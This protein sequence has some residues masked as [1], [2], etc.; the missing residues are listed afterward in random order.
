MQNEG[1]EGPELPRI[2]QSPFFNLQFAV[3]Y[4]P[5]AQSLPLSSVCENWR[6]WACARSR[7]L[8]PPCRFR[9]SEATVAIEQLLK[10]VPAAALSHEAP[11][12]EEDNALGPWREAAARIVE[13]ADDDEVW[14]RL[15]WGPASSVPDQETALTPFRRV[16]RPF[17][18]PDGEEGRHVR[19][20]LQA[21]QPALELLELGIQRGRVQLPESQDTQGFCESLDWLFAMR[22]A[23]YLFRA[24]AMAAAA[25]GDLEVA[26]RDLLNILHVGEILCNAEIFVFGYLRGV[27]LQRGV[28]A[29][30]RGLAG[31]AGLPDRVR[32]ALAAGLRS[33]LAQPSDLARCVRCELRNWALP[34]VDCLPE[35]KDLETLVKTW[36]EKHTND[37]TWEFELDEATKRAKLEARRAQYRRDLLFLLE[38]HPRPFDKVATAR[39]VGWY[40]ADTILR[41]RP[42]TPWTWLNLPRLCSRWWHRKHRRWLDRQTRRWPGYY[43]RLGW[44]EYDA[45]PDDVLKDM[46]ESIGP[47]GVE[48]T[49]RPTE[50]QL[51]EAKPRLRR[52]GNPLGILLANSL[53]ADMISNCE[54]FQR[55]LVLEKTELAEQLESAT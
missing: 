44:I 43:W 21:N 26:A 29:S 45:A 19:D 16:T 27:S 7:E 49:T 35:D 48:R 25:D 40:A 14:N 9:A 47:G 37:S 6:W 20:V 33:S 38:G 15:H 42:P 2:F 11:L 8:V 46:Q 3:F 18:F 4:P 51:Q 12:A 17:T 28:M 24:R 54:E 53:D 23:C 31:V 50:A 34:Y 13:P 41:L 52:V 10:H 30:M 22:N 5:L 55:Q 36:V 1:R 32:A 39:L